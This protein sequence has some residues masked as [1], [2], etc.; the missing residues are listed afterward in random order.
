MR[1][2][3]RSILERMVQE[4]SVSVP[5]NTVKKVVT[6]VKR[7]SATKLSD[8]TNLIRDN[9]IKIKKEK[10]VR[11]GIE[12]EFYSNEDRDKAN[13]LVSN[14]TEESDKKLTFYLV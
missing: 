14:R 3:F 6:E 10:P 5:K 2:N 1:T 8:I 12:V 7:E 4:E 13:N 9:M 11:D